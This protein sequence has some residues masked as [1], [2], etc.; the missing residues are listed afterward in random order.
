MK[1]SRISYLLSVPLLLLVLLLAACAGSGGVEDGGI[2]DGGG[3]EP[4]VTEETPTEGPLPE[5]GVT[6]EAT[7]ET[8]EAT[9]EATTEAPAATEE[10]T[11]EAPAATGEATTEA[12]AGVTTEPAV[13][14]GEEGITLQIEENDQLGPILTDGEGMTLYILDADQAGESTCYDACAELWPPVTISSDPEVGEEVNSTLIGVIQR[15]DGQSQLT[16]NQHPLYYYE[17]DESAGDVQGHQVTDA[18]GLWTAVSPEGEA[19]STAS[20]SQGG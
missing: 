8:P 14:G 16:Y 3:G 19:I 20:P 4:G 18:W 9:E 2:T 7:T 6:E 15:T 17:P 12:P 11:T 5:V 10:A 13:P 1:K